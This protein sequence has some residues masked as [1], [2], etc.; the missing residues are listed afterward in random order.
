MGDTVG[1]IGDEGRDG[2]EI[3][4]MEKAWLDGR[5]NHALHWDGYGKAHHSAGHVSNIPGFSHVQPS[6]DVRRVRVLC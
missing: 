2:T 4:I 6:L 5:V 3:E 1:R